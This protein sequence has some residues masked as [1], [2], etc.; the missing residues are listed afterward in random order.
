MKLFE[1]ALPAWYSNAVARHIAFGILVGFTLSVA[2]TSRS[3]SS[4]W[5]SRRRQS[6]SQEQHEF[7][8]I[9]LRSDEVVHGVTGL[10]GT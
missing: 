9:V 6:L 4:Y 2:S 8:P 7:R 1:L 10:I 3:I 5:R